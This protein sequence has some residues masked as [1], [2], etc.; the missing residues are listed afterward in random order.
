[1]LI[2][3]IANFWAHLNSKLVVRRSSTTRID[4]E[5][6]GSTFDESLEDDVSNDGATKPYA[7]ANNERLSESSLHLSC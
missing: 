4:P 5:R 3:Q 2:K 1:M 7:P 6:D